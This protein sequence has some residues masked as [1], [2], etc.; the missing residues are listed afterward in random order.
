MA[1][2]RAIRFLKEFV[3]QIRP[4]LVFIS[5]TFTKKDKIEEICNKIGF[6]GCWSVDAYGHGGGLVFFWK[7][8]G[9]VEIKDSCQHYIDIEVEVEVEQVK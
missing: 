2:R 7:N 6:A 3:T 4:S 5:E 9:G 1:N 8:E